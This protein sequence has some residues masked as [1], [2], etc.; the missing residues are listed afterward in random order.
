MGNW[1]ALALSLALLG[2]GLAGAWVGRRST[3]RALALGALVLLEFV[4]TTAFVVADEFTGNGVDESVLYHATVGIAGAGLSEYRTLIGGSVALVALGLAL[5]LTSVVLLGR[6]APERPLPTAWGALALGALAAA[7][8]PATTGLVRAS[9]GEDALA[10]LERASSGKT[11]DF[12]HHYRAPVLRQAPARQRNFIYIYAEGLERTYFDESI[13]PGLMTELRK[14]EAQSTSFTDIRQ[15]YGTGFTIGGIVASQCGIPLLMSSGRFSSDS[16][17]KFLPRAVCLGDLL[18]EQ[19]YHLVYMGGAALSFAGKGK[20]LTNHGFSE[21]LGRS[22]LLPRQADPKYRSSWGLHD[23]T[24]FELAFEKLMELSARGESFGLFLLTLDTHHPDGHQARAV[25]DVMY[26]DGKVRM[27]NAVAGADRMISAFIER[28]RASELGKDTVIVVASDHLAMSN[29]A[30]RRL[31]RGERRNLFMIRDPKAPG[32]RVVDKLGT[33]LDIGPTLLHA[34]GYRAELGLGRD[35]SSKQ[36]SLVEAL[37]DLRRAFADWRDDLL[38]FWGFEA[39]DGLEIRPDDNVVLA[40]DN[41]LRIPALI[42]LDD[43]LSPEVY[44]GYRSS[45]TLRDRMIDL[46]SGAAFVWVTS[47][48]VGRDYAGLEGAD[49]SALC[50]IAG[51]RGAEPVIATSIAEQRTLSEA[52]LRQ[53]VTAPGVQPSLYAEQTLRLS[54]ARL[55]AG[56]AELA[57]SAPPGTLFFRP[58]DKKAP[59]Y[60]EHYLS[61][62]ELGQTGLKLTRKLPK[63]G[64]FY[65]AEQ[66]EKLVRKKRSF[67][68]ERLSP[69]SALFKASAEPLAVERR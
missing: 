46:P 3:Y 45:V 38:A 50:V 65:F 59:A 9:L 49:P 14:V 17:A 21:V 24:L 44:F 68:I 37:P 15:A 60:V 62:P 61:L 66:H 16:M 22:E 2:A 69:S 18:R 67:R 20:F 53:V 27:L 32:G 43:E 19:G 41:T 23:D 4:L 31:E 36:V 29:G 5:A 42:L 30:T 33:T 55:P 28:V 57:A 25:K 34:L 52:E 63:T 12:D 47:C 10:A 6:R 1:T 35:L 64:E 11:S 39:L 58:K 26:E 40:G 13:F 51:R 54:R 7:I 8:H 56:F 48:E